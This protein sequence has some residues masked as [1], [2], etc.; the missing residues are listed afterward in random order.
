M[1][2]AAGRAGAPRGQGR[3]RS[4]ASY[5][6]NLH[7]LEDVWVK[8]CCQGLSDLLCENHLGSL[9][10]P[11]HKQN[12]STFAIL[13]CFCFRGESLTGPDWLSRKGQETDPA[14][15]QPE[16]MWV[17]NCNEESVRSP[18]PQLQQLWD[19][20]AKAPFCR[21]HVAPWVQG[22]HTAPQAQ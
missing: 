16:G 20:S 4:P 13:I 10:R 3:D 22:F 21:D 9:V 1:V 17:N 8:P 15:L 11:Q 19:S 12:H 18:R 7:P 5:L 2:C 14:V 6:P